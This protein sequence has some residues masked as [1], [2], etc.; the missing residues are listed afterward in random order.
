ME[1]QRGRLAEAE[2]QARLSMADSAAEVEGALLLAQ[3]LVRR[4]DLPQALA[5]LDEA[6]R[7]ATEEKRAPARGLGPLRADVLAR[8]GR[9]AEAEAALR[10]DIRAFPGTAQTYARA[11]RS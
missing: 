11:W 7:R 4:S 6:G 9:F 5:V 10:E 8:L 3:V 2:R 1:L